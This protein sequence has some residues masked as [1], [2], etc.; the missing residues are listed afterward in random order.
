M[1]TSECP[2]D[3]I[4]DAAMATEYLC[5]YCGQKM[6]DM[7]ADMQPCPLCG[8]FRFVVEVVG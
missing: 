8:E 2:R 1:M 6:T 4:A 3:D 7:H 5:S